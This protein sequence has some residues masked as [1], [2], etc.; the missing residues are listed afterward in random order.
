MTVSTTSTINVRV[1][2]PGTGIGPVG[3]N[4]ASK[5]AMVA[6][7]RRRAHFHLPVHTRIVPVRH[8]QTLLSFDYAIS[9]STITADRTTDRTI[10]IAMAGERSERAGEVEC[11]NGNSR[12]A[13]GR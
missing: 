13:D 11:I 3:H 9:T 12:G 10:A 7:G 8:G 5:G 1:V 4:G 6:V 2:N